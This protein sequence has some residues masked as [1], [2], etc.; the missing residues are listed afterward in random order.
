[1]KITV[2]FLKPETLIIPVGWD[3]VEHTPRKVVDDITWEK[4]HMYGVEGRDDVAFIRL[5]ENEFEGFICGITDIHYTDVV[6]QS[7]PITLS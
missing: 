7:T 1:M 5:T 2:F 4:E 3:G 6:D